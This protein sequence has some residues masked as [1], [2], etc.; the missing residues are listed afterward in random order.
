MGSNLKVGQR[1]ASD[2]LVPLGRPAGLR[3]LTPLSYAVS[4]PGLLQQGMEAS[5]FTGNDYVLLTVT[6]RE[7]RS[8]AHNLL[9]NSDPPVATV[10]A[11]ALA[12]ATAQGNHSPLN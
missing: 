8:L 11:A 5:P 9:A 4:T 2:V 1:R 12:S 10:S 7:T 3:I 6:G